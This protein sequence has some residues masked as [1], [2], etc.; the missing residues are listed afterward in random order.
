MPAFKI[1]LPR[2]TLRIRHK[3]ILCI[4]LVLFPVLIVTEG[5]IYYVNYRTVM[6]EN[7][8]RYRNL[9]VT[10]DENISF[11]ESDLMDITTYFC[12]NDDILRLLSSTDLSVA[13]TDTL[14]WKRIPLTGVINDMISI[15]SH[16][17]TLVLYPE[18]GLPPYYVS[19]DASVHNLSLMDLHKTPLYQEAVAAQGDHVWALIKAG[20]TSSIFMANRSDKI[21]ICREIFDMSKA[22]RLGFLALTID[23]Q[24]YERTLQNVLQYDNEA[25]Y[26]VDQHG[27]V[28]AQVGSVDE[29]SLAAVHAGRFDQPSAG[30]S[31]PQ[32]G[33]WY[34]FSQEHNIS[35]EMIYYF[36]PRAN[37][38][39]WITSG[40][41]LPVM[42]ALALLVCIWPLS[43]L[44]SHLFSLPLNRLYQSMNRF[45][46][47]DF[48][49]RVEVSGRD[50][51]SE[52]STT[53]NTMVSDLRDLID[54]NYVMVLRERESE[55]TALQAQINPHFLYNTLDS[56][57]WQASRNGQ[58]NLA[59]DILS[60]S[61]LFRL[62]LSSGQGIIP[63]ER[64]VQI[65]SHYLHIQKMRFAKKLDYSIQIQPEMNQYM[66]CKLILQ[67]FVENAI[68]HG[69]ECKDSWGCVQVTGE[70]KDEVLCFRVEDN[71]VG[72]TA[73][74][75]ETILNGAEDK[76]YANQRIGHYAIRNVKERLSL[77]YGDRYLLAIES[78]PGKGTVIQIEVPAEV[79]ENDGV[80]TPV[81]CRG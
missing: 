30:L 33:K 36:S 28:L 63:V 23:R 19:R 3:I 39:E 9:V 46:S 7:V 77:S 67:P 24:W 2:P 61:E 49:Q 4:Y 17:S 79:E 47:G 42:L 18:N 71:G 31:P 73:E 5:M 38:N 50:E 66:I 20:D 48:N 26:M 78:T 56:L 16:V 76:R 64:E 80:S 72:M 74:Q 6:E 21:A 35:G 54:R 41:I 32:S 57:Y 34:V 53:F 69:L 55:L 68:V 43:A 60:L 59:E 45:K 22:H 51:I 1:P 37:W 11:V 40:L 58:E 12:V 14:F 62:L 52:I 27:E 75:V 44:A 15:K 25:I 81:N 29:Q 13:S 65:I 10:L 8:R 70:L